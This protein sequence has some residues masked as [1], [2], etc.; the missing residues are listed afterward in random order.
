MSDEQR[1]Q[2]RDASASTGDSRTDLHPVPSYA[3]VGS[4]RAANQTGAPHAAAPHKAGPQQAGPSYGLPP[5][6]ASPTAGSY[7]GGAIPP[8]G[9]PFA[10]PPTATLP[11]QPRKQRTMGSIVAA[12]LVAG[13]VGG[14]AGFGGAYAVL[15]DRSS[16]TLNSAPSSSNSVTAPAGAVAAA[17]QTGMPS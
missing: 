8:P 14:A 7:P 16:P 9:G 4:G 6:G 1:E 3:A 10:G 2:G 15:G 11:P 12:A 13:L 5:A 17:G